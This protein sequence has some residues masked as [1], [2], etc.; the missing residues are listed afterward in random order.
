M[1]QLSYPPVLS[2]PDGLAQYCQLALW[3]SRQC[4]ETEYRTAYWKKMYCS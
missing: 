3:Q 1:L 4:Y 2:L